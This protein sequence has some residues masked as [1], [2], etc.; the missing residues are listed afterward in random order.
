[1]SY[2][3][4]GRIARRA[5]LAIRELEKRSKP[6]PWPGRA[7]VRRG[8][9]DEKLGK[10]SYSECVCGYESSLRLPPRG[11]PSG[12]RVSIVSLGQVLGDGSQDCETNPPRF[13]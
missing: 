5:Y 8:K 9:A 1:M 6:D 13:R 3:L 7:P 4:V 2:N 10:Q 11:D 12:V